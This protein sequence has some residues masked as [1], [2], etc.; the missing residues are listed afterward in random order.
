[1]LLPPR[2]SS[3]A[4][5][6]K[7][8]TVSNTP[9]RNDAEPSTS[10][11]TAPTN[12]TN[13][14]TETN[15]LDNV[16]AR[17]IFFEH[18]NIKEVVAKKLPERS[19]TT[20]QKYAS[21]LYRLYLQ[22]PEQRI[23][24]HLHEVRFDTRF[25]EGL[26]RMALKMPL[27]SAQDWDRHKETLAKGGIEKVC[28]VDMTQCNRVLGYQKK[29]IS[30][31][32][33]Q[34][35]HWSG[36]LNKLPSYLMMC[37]RKRESE[38]R[39]FVSLLKHH[40]TLKNSRTLQIP[41][42]VKDLVC[43]RWLPSERRTLLIWIKLRFDDDDLN[44]KYEVGEYSK[45]RYNVPVEP[46]EVV[47]HSTHVIDL[48]DEENIPRDNNC[49][50]VDV[51]RIIQSVESVVPQ[52]NPSFAV[53]L[54]TAKEITEIR[55]SSAGRKRP[56]E[57]IA[58][59]SKQPESASRPTAANHQPRPKLKKKDPI[60]RVACPIRTARIAYD[61]DTSL[62]V[63]DQE[64][65]HHSIAFVPVVEENVT[66]QPQ[67]REQENTPLSEEFTPFACSTQNQSPPTKRRSAQYAQESQTVATQDPLQ[68]TGTGTNTTI[69]QFHVDVPSN[70]GSTQ[71]SLQADNRATQSQS[72]P[73]SSVIPPFQPANT[74][75]DDCPMTT[76]PNVCMTSSA[77]KPERPSQPDASEYADDVEIVS[78]DNSVIYI[79]DSPNVNEVNFSDFSNSLDSIIAR[80]R[81]IVDRSKTNERVEEDEYYLS[82]AEPTTSTS[83]LEDQA[84]Q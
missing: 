13:K 14:N 24:E 29:V 77:V 69:P 82:C 19:E 55:D 60:L 17:E 12:D 79:S 49:T 28:L 18:T 64:A 52:D 15:S 16:Y 75:P 59:P 41:H 10:K 39:K 45:F 9:T 47:E 37:Q 7:P 26:F 70:L 32:K 8:L 3:T 50:V 42:V 23:R 80:V 1:M 65:A 53:P 5:V 51:T 84:E 40:S 72:Q 4:T 34:F 46:A 43:E 27:N 11:S 81:G 68:L 78:M 61:S 63:S 22:E 62:T 20:R 2:Q 38:D 73:G 44:K 31:V 83:S 33:E 48:D 57:S 66:S 56:L 58:S 76:I 71:I 25:N 6:P 30:Q 74:T 36:K 67:Q 54:H 35:Q 21:M